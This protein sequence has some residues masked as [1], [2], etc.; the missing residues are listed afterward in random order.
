MAKKSRFATNKLFYLGNGR[1]QAHKQAY[2]GTLIR[3]NIRSFSWF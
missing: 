3:N 1:R 2:N